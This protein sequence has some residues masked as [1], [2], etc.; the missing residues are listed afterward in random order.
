MPNA[1]VFTLICAA[2]F[3]SSTC[4]HNAAKPGSPVESGT[5]LSSIA[6]RPAESVET[7]DS[8]RT[9]LS[10]TD[11]LERSYDQVQFARSTLDGHPLLFFLGPSAAGTGW[12][13]SGLFIFSERGTRTQIRLLFSALGAEGA[14]GLDSLVNGAVSYQ[15]KGCLYLRDDD[16]VG[17][18]LEGSEQNLLAAQAAKADPY[19]AEPGYYKLNEAGDTLLLIAPP[20]SMLIS[21]CR[22]D[23]GEQR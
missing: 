12:T 23:Q 14:A 21:K 18:T 4:T 6:W 5:T 15:L 9:A 7:I 13:Q 20:D 17:Y 1:R 11:I 22:A 3:A 8:L 19:G 10:Q 16:A 2:S